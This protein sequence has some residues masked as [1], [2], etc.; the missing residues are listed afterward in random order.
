MLYV[1]TNWINITINITLFCESKQAEKVTLVNIVTVTGQI[2]FNPQLK[3]ICPVGLMY[4]F[5]WAQYKAKATQEC[6]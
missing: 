2:S 1:K 5:Q 4:I 3:L 6:L